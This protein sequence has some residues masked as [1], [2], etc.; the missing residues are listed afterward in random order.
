MVD[1]R[2][3]AP[4]VLTAAPARQAYVFFSAEEELALLNYRDKQLASILKDRVVVARKRH[5]RA[6]GKLDWPRVVVRADE[7]C[8]PELASSDAADW[9]DHL[10]CHR[11]GALP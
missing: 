4:A 3:R 5:Y 1:R 9:R 6:T 11:P 8:V 7:V 2:L 10:V